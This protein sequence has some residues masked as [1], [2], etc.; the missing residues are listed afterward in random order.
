MNCSDEIRKKCLTYRLNLGSKCL[1]LRRKVRKKSNWQYPLNWSNCKFF[2]KNVKN[3]PLNKY[4]LW[5]VYFERIKK[6]F[7][8]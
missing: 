6:T 8:N 4:K 1:L 5:S 3:I 7:N 2:N